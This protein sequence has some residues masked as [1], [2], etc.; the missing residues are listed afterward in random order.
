MVDNTQS[1]MSGKVWSLSI[2]GALV[3]LVF[4]SLGQIVENLDSTEE[5]VIQYPSGTLVAVTEPGWTM[6][7]FGSVTKYPLRTQFSFSSA[8]DQ[9]D[10]KDNSVVLRFNDGGHANVSGVVSWEMPTD[11]EHLISIHRKFGSPKAIEQQIIRPTI[12]SAAYTSG[13][14]MSSTESAAEK[15]NLLLQ[16]MQ[17]QAKNGPYQTRTV[18]IKVA[19]PLTGVEKT[20]NAAEIVVE[21]GKPVREQQSA[22]T[23]F[24]INLLPMTINQIKYDNDI[25]KQIVDRQKS[26]QGVQIAQA[27]ALKAEQDAITAAKQG[28]AKAAEA[29]W[30]QETIKAQKVTEAQ[31][32]LEVATLAAKQ[33]E[34]YKQQKILEGQGDAEKQKLIMAANGALD[35][36]LVAF[37]E[38]QKAYA[39]AI[40]SYKGNWVPTTVMGGN[41]SSNTN[42]AMQLL[43]LIAAK[44]ARDLSIDM[45]IESG[46]SSK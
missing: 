13:P 40:A 5:M 29:K 41:G 32:Q 30:A 15:R 7:W 35:Q 21:N 33:A 46:K 11:A 23:M 44:T 8:L 31:Q 45:T 9:G 22:A 18:T 12:E 37:V 16:Y 10:A 17:D 28:E 3:L 1:L 20:V 36:K 2:I 24:S 39:D 34:Q 42:G 25:E 14:L 19:D 43:D 38:I 26:I 4:L 6:Q 27:N